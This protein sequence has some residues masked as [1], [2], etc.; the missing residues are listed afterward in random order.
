MSLLRI[1]RRSLRIRL[2][3]WLSG[4]AIIVTGATWLLHGIL[5]QDLARDFLGERLK[6]EAEHAIEQVKQDDISAPDVLDSA[7]HGFQAFHHLYVLRLGNDTSSSDP[8]WVEA[9]DFLLDDTRDDLVEVRDGEQHLLV[10]RRPF[11]LEE[12]RGVLLVGEDFSQLDAGLHELHW[13]VAAIAAVLL[14]LLVMLNILAVNRGLIPLSRLRD[15]LGELRTGDRDRLSLEVPSE[16]DSLVIQLNRFMDEIDSRLQRSR[17][18]VA[19]LSHALKTPLAAVTQVLQGARP[20]DDVRRK[21]LVQRLEEIHAQLDAELRRSRIAGP[22][23][24]RMSDLHRDCT[25]LID[26][27]RGLYPNID[28][29]MRLPEEIEKRVPIE[30]QDFS[31]ML[32]IVLD[33]AGKWASSRVDCRIVIDDGLRITVEDDGPGIAADDLPRLGQ[34]GRRL[35][36]RHPGYGLGLS[37][38]GQ[39]MT[40]YTGEVSYRV[41]ALGGLCVEMEVPIKESPT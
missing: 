19:N 14:L 26:M 40:R 5:L 35:D 22:N 21:K 8:R 28:F 41:S 37:I 33:N 2:L 20:I 25:R 12:E 27:F 31:E 17:D 29:T 6:R 32:G 34:R 4:I 16:L 18:S 1:D 9:L 30:S 38:L 3:G 13:W 39:L 23:A 10:Y 11:S 7:S 36:E 24:G 15:Q